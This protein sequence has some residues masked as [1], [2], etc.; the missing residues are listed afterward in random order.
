[1]EKV[2]ISHFHTQTLTANN[3]NAVFSP[4]RDKKSFHYYISMCIPQRLLEHLSGQAT[5][6]VPVLN[7]FVKSRWLVA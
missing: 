3:T 4:S 6:G 5:H 2:Y 7:G 1:M